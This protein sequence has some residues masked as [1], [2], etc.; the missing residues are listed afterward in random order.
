MEVRE[1]ALSGAACYVTGMANDVYSLGA[2]AARGATMLEIRCGRCDRHGRLSVARLLAEH[3]PNAEFSTI[4]RGLVG[5]CPHRDEQQIQ[6]RCDPYCPDLV[7]L[8]YK[9]G[10]GRDCYRKL[11]FPVIKCVCLSEPTFLPVGG[12]QGPRLRLA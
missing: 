4:M 8:L 9:L 7:R 1:E 10:L 12:K 5:D 6:N 2:I 3:G 11:R